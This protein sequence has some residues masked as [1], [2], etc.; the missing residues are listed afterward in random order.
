M[1]EMGIAS[2]I[3]EAVRKEQLLYPGYRATKVGVR[4]GELSF[5]PGFDG[6]LPWAF[7]GNR[8]FLCCLHGFGLYL[9]KQ[10]RLQE[11]EGIL[12]KLLRFDPTDNLD[13]RHML[14][15][16]RAESPWHLTPALKS[17]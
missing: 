2:S 13:A 12:E 6:L 5:D 17:T 16:V 14:E 15:D 1:H 10:G 11:A 8:P 4:I 3:L 7:A 9:W